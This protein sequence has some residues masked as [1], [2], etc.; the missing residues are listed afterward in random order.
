MKIVKLVGLALEGFGATITTTAAIQ[1]IMWL[2]ITG[3]IVSGLGRSCAM[4]VANANKN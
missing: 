3:V 1:N 4:V 2:V